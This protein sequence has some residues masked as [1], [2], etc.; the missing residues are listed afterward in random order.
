MVEDVSSDP[1]NAELNEDHINVEIDE[2]ENEK[3]EMVNLEDKVGEP[4]TRM[5]FES[6]DEVFSY[7]TR[8]AKQNGFAVAKRTGKKGGDEV[9]RYLTFK[10]TRSGKPRI[11]TSNP[12]RPRPQTKM[13]CKA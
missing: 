13:G 8:Y 7:Y 11:R 2:T 6:V 5:M 10:C 4:K 9:I 1:S 12:V 3:G